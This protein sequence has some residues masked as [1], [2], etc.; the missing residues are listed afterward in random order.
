MGV[1]LMLMTIGGLAVATILLGIAWLHD[2]SWLRRFV[3]GSV[4]IWFLFYAVMLIGASLMST[5][6]TIALGDTDGKAFCGFYLDCHMHTAVMNV[7]RSKTIGN[8]TALG[9]F[10]IVRVKVFSDAKQATLGLITVDAHVVD[11]SGATYARDIVAET[12]LPPQPDFEQKISP[13][14]SFEKQIV[15]DL[16]VDVQNPRLDTREGS[17]LDRLV[18]AFLVGDE[19]SI[20]HKRSYFSLEAQRMTAR[21]K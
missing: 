6:R 13:I 19:D 7:T 8:K 20:L 11:A 9:E 1:L 12:Q 15:F 16:P 21:A 3:L 17:G 10:Y 4:A 5:E 18:E 2:S 14:E